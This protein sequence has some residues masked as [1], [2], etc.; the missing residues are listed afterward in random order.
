MRTVFRFAPVLVAISAI[1]R[2]M[3]AP[4]FSTGPRVLG[5]GN[6]AGGL[7]NP[8]ANMAMAEKHVSVMNRSICGPSPQGSKASHACFDHGRGAVQSGSELGSIRTPYTCYDRYIPRSLRPRILAFPLPPPS[9]T[10]NAFDIAR[11]GRNPLR[12]RSAPMDRLC[13]E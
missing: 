1:E 6:E 5:A 7:A 3:F 2:W 12:S 11:Y 13:G 10:P 9:M 8:A 4:Y